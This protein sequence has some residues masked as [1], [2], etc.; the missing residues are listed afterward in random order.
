MTKCYLYFKPESFYPVAEG[1]ILR[2][3][4]HNQNFDTKQYEV[5]MEVIGEAPKDFKSN[6][7]FVDTAS[8]PK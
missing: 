7:V 3:M 8:V 1:T 2:Y 4:G 6:V 5:V